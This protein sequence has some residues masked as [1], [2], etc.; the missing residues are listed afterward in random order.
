MKWLL[1]LFGLELKKVP[2][3]GMIAYDRGFALEDNPY[4][5]HTPDHSIWRDDWL[6]SARRGF[7]G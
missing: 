2:S 1:K 4:R 6:F 5:K 7:Y 3:D